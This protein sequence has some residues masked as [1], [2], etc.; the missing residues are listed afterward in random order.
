MEHQAMSQG[1]RVLYRFVPTKKIEVMTARGKVYLFDTESD[2]GRISLRENEYEL[3]NLFNGHRT[4][5]EIRDIV[6]KAKGLSLLAEDLRDFVNKL[7]SAGLLKDAQPP[8]PVPVRRRIQSAPAQR[9]LSRSGAEAA[10]AVEAEDDFPPLEEDSN[11]VLPG[12]GASA[13]RRGPR[14]RRSLARDHAARLAFE[15]A[16]QVE[17]GEFA[18]DEMEELDSLLQSESELGSPE[19]LLEEAFAA[20]ADSSE[21][22][23]R[24]RQP[25]RRA[26]LL[27]RLPVRWLLPVAAP[28][29]WAGRNGYAA[30]LLGCLMCAAAVGLWMGRV[31]LARDLDR[32]FVPIT[33]LQSLL[34]G[35]VTVNLWAQLARAAEFKR[36]LGEAPPFGIA[37][38]WNILPVFATDLS[39]LAKARDIRAAQ[40][41][42]AASLSTV[43]TIWLLTFGG[44]MASKNNG[45]TAP[46]LL[47]GVAF[48]ATIRLVLT[49]N[50]LGRRDGYYLMALALGI[51]DLRQR[52]FATLLRRDMPPLPPSARVNPSGW[53]LGHLWAGGAG[54]SRR[55]FR[56]GHDCRRWP[57]RVPLG[58]LRR[59][60]LRHTGGPGITGADSRGARAPGISRAVTPALPLAHAAPALRGNS[61]GRPGAGNP[62]RTGADSL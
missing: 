54:L 37:L 49:L 26:R 44:W 47:L 29:G 5:E 25:P 7:A 43:A 59:N 41:I 45:T 53:V 50:P 10:D 32:W 46:L 2:E 19:E 12:A 39:G 61:Q 52:A 56:A 42:F 20:G 4:E 58:R 31:E 17:D 38:A 15:D 51:P 55:H 35:L 33:V 57:A 30:I 23:S 27:L 28:L 62:H 8:A 48:M 1:Q 34:L 16:P 36:Q 24:Q 11:R 22:R 18:T 13:P 21:A 6:Q 9:R 40:A 14:P 60:P 3:A